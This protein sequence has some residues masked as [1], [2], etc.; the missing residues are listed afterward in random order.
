VVVEEEVRLEEI[1][2]EHAGEGAGAW[3]EGSEE[4]L[5]LT[6]TIRELEIVERTHVHANT[7]RRVKVAV[8]QDS[9]KDRDF[10]PGATVEA[11][12]EWA[13]GPEGF[14]LLPAERVK[15]TFVI[16]GTQTE[17]DRSA[18]IGSYADDKCTVCFNL[19]PKQRNE[20]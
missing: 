14:D 2:R 5:D 18:H 12:Y 16:C 3:C 6:L 8:R 11:V 19:V 15:H 10:P 20:G 1:V 4:E 7:C 13:S 9:E 17:P